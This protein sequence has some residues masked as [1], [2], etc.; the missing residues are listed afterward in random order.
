MGRGSFFL[1]RSDAVEVIPGLYIGADPDRRA[2]AALSRAGVSHVVD[3]RS[4][5]SRVSRWPGEVTVE[6]CGLAEYQAPS[7][8]DLRKIAS[9][10]AELLSSGATVFIHCREGIQRAPM[11]ACA[12]LM[13]AGWT[14]ADA[15]RLVSTRRPV[16]AMS[17]VQLRVLRELDANRGAPSALTQRMSRSDE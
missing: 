17:E 11:V 1:G 9:R 12:V 15:F 16:T 14:L 3:L 13:E 8:E 10:G 4:D 5:A 6:V 7:A 2:V